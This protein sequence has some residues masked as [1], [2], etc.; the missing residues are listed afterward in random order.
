VN[1][2]GELTAKIVIKDDY[3]RADGT[4]ALHLQVF[5]MGKRK[6]LPI[7]ISVAPIDFDKKKQRVKVKAHF[8]KDYNLIIEKALA[9]IN[10]I[11]ISYRLAGEVLDI[12]KLVNEYQNPSSRID[13]IKFWELEMVN[14]KETRDIATYKQ[15]MSS[16][17]KVK[18]Y[19]ESILFYE[20]TP[21]FFEKMIRYF[22]KVKKN[23]PN[24]IQT[25]SKNFKK[26]LHIA[27][28][29]G[30]VTPLNFKDIKTTR[31]V[32]NRTFLDA[33][34]I[35]RL[36][37]YYTSEFINESLKAILGRFLFSCFTGL[38]ISDIKA[39]TKENIVGDI[40]IFFSQKTGKLQRIQLNQSAL[41]FV[42]DDYIFSGDYSEAHINRELKVIAKTCGIK[43]HITFHVA[44]H[45]FATNFLIC[46]GRVEILQK[47]L[48]HGNIRE[49]MDYVHIVESIVEQ[50]INNLDDILKSDAQ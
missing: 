15:Q 41:S 4:C 16:L 37:Q 11:E 36:N 30:I 24:T 38:R 40:L 17:R 44:R 35:K 1:F 21:L 3:V 27:N 43:K 25:V 34:E 18:K 23:E 5:I 33:V 14:Q 9:D 46:G 45:S 39:I 20:I 6:K 47:L 32:S 2:S 31:C 8:A 26:Y 12:D 19:K 22:E 7:Y 29:K 42:G 48:G 10:K 49:T 28:N 13:F 50:Q